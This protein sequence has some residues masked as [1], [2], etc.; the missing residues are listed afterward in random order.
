MLLSG[1]SSQKGAGG[2]VSCIQRMTVSVF[3]WG[4][5]CVLTLSLWC[6]R[7]SGCYYPHS[8]TEDMETQGG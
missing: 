5:I 1:Y 7:P 3:I 2:V 8:T 6:G 4:V